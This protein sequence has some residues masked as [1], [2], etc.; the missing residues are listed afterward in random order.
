MKRIAIFFDTNILE[1]RFSEKKQE[2]LFHYKIIPNE[3]FNK[4]I[5]YI[6]TNNIEN[7]T[8]FCVCTVSL[9]ELKN[10]LVE[11][12]KNRV[13]D[14]I[15]QEAVYKKAFGPSVEILYEFEHKN[16]EEYSKYIEKKLNVF[17]EEYKCKL[18][19]YP[20]DINFYKLLIDKCIDKKE[21]F[22]T[23]SSQGKIYTDAGLKDAIIFETI[24][25]YGHD[26]DC[27]TIL[28]SKDNDFAN[29]RELYTCNS[30]VKLEEYLFEHSYISNE[31]AIK[32]KIQSDLYLRET[33]ISMTDNKLDE[34]V[35]E[36]EVKNVV[37]NEDDPNCFNVNI[38]CT[39]NESIYIIDCTYD[40]YSNNVELDSYKIE[41]E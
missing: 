11:N 27:L 21:P 19:D 2:F 29:T 6:K 17:L 7:I 13:N 33:I 4:T 25:R 18:I 28:V 22:K 41:N 8:D 32:N 23:A 3:L 31:N 16:E 12:Y 38:K 5:N 20:N 24:I 36:F 1:S 37:K 26:N 30:I 34:S 15:H 14:F 35:T 40:F 9:K 10:H 39:I